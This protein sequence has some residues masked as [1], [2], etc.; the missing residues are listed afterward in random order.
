VAVVVA[1][2]LILALGAAWLVN[3]PLVWIAAGGV[4]TAIVLVRSFGKAPKKG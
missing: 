4:I 3:L 1:V 2:M